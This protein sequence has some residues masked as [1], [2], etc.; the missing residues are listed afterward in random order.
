MFYIKFFLVY[1]FL[2]GYFCNFKKNCWEIFLEGFYWVIDQFWDYCDFVIFNFNVYL[3]IELLE[4]QGCVYGVEVS[5]KGCS[6]CF[7]GQLSYIY[8]C[9]ECQ[10]VGIN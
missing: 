2:L 4:G 10:V 8:L 6:L 7:D 9:M 3:E 1:N 5:V